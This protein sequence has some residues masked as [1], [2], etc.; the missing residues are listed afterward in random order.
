MNGVIS[1]FQGPGIQGHSHMRF[2]F[3]EERNVPFLF[4]S[5]V[6]SIRPDNMPQLLLQ[7]A[8]PPSLS[9]NV[10]LEVPPHAEQYTVTHIL[11]TS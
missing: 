1:T 5:V 10:N 4:Q 8:A 9:I 3:V 7:T 6:A 11:R 2:A